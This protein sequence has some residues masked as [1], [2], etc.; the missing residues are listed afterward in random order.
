[1]TRVCCATGQL[2]L[3]KNYPFEGNGQSVREGGVRGLGAGR[4][5]RGRAVFRMMPGFEAVFLE[6]N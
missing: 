1:M 5:R 4:L 6:L 3:I 2:R